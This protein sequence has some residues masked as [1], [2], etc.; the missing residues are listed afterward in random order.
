MA[1]LSSCPTP[2]KSRRRHRCRAKVR[3]RVRNWPT[4]NRGLKQRDDLIVW[5]PTDLADVWYYQGPKSGGAIHLFRPSHPNRADPADDLS[6]APAQAEGFVGSVPAWMG[7][8]LRVPDYS[9]R[10]LKIA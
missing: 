10:M 1:K 9:T 5:F 2:V 4:Y 6:Y 8:S 7:L 3:Y